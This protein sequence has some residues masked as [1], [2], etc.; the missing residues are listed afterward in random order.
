[1]SKRYDVII[2][3]CG[4]TGATAGT[5]LAQR[6]YSV[7]MLDRAQFPRKKLCGGLLTWK[8]VKLLETVFGEDV[9]SL[10]QSG[11]INH[12]SNHYAIRSYVNTLA[13]GELPFPFHFVDRTVFDDHLLSR[14]KQAGAEVFEGAKIVSCDPVEGLVTLENGDVF[15]GEYII[16]ADGANSVIRNS[17]PNYDRKRFKEFMAPA[18]E[19]SLSPSDF[20]RPVEFPELIVG[21][22]DAGYGWVFPNRDR[23]VVGIC[24]LRRNNVNFSKL[25]DSYLDYLKIDKTVVS[26]LHGH[27]L[28]YGN[29]LENPVYGKTLLA[30]DAG[31]F[32][33]PLFGEGLFFAMATGL[34]ASEAIADGLAKKCSAGPAYSQRV[35]QQIIPELKA[36]N[37]LRWL[38]FKGMKLAGPRSLGLFV[39][40]GAWKLAE[41]VHGIRSYSWLRKKRWDFL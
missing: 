10:V 24:G 41:M 22:M 15:E 1:M 38:L 13:E 17:F 8:S 32:V 2:C 4:P 25:F 19:I 12:V 6:G 3:G 39:N 11:V 31:G 14:A 33:E 28:P 26:D 18:I 23:V 9:D 16:G 34:Y 21:F 7:A 29:Y 20:P 27:P 30:G 5:V 36:S 40:A 35:H 37:R